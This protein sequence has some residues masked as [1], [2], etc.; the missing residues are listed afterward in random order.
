VVCFVVAAAGEGW[1][2]GRLGRRGLAPRVVLVPLGLAL[3]VI[4]FMYSAYKL[5]WP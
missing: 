4:P 2:F 1:K 5:G 3:F